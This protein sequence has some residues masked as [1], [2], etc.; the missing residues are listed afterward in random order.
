MFYSFHCTNLLPSW[1]SLFIMCCS[2]LWYY[3][4]IIFFITFWNI[5]SIQNA[6][7]FYM[8]TLYSATLLNLLGQTVFCEILG[9]I[10]CKTISIIQE[11]RS[12][13]IFFFSLDVLI[14][15]SCLVPLAR[16]SNTMLNKIN[17]TGHVGFS[18]KGLNMFTI[19]LFSLPKLSVFMKK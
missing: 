9:V 19:E 1:L 12:F 5:Y 4:D 7:D 10:T 6:D 2:A 8:S 17:E 16:T 13:Y 11:Q 15:L 14:S 3:N 18:Y